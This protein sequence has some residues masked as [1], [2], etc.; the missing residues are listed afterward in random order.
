MARPAGGIEVAA[1][2]STEASEQVAEAF[3]A[4]GRA[5]RAWQ[6]YLPNNPTR[7]RAVELA[8]TSLQ[9]VLADHP[10]GLTVSVR[11]QAFAQ[12]GV[13]VY[14]ETARQT[15]SLPWLMYRDGVR[16]LTFL[17]GFPEEGLAKLLGVLQRARQAAPDE[18]DLVTLLWM[19]GID[20]FKYRVVELGEPG[21]F[22]VAVVDEDAFTADDRPFG[23][24]DAEGGPAGAHVPAAES[25]L[26]SGV[27]PGLVRVE[28]FDSA[29]VFLN[30]RELA[31]L[32]DEMQAEFTR[33]PRPSVLA[34]LLDIIETQPDDAVRLEAVGSLEGLLVDQLTTRSYDLSAAT[35]REVRETMRRATELSAQVRDALAELA[36]RLSEPDAIAQLLDSV[37]SS[38]TAT[39][40]ETLEALATEWRVG[41]LGP[42]LAWLASAPIGV[43]RAAVERAAE[44]LA[45]QHDSE[46]VRHLESPDPGTAS[47]AIR[48][49]GQLRIEAAVPVLGRLARDAAGSARLEATLAL[50]T[51]GGLA[52]LR[53]IEP[54]IEDEDRD[55]RLAAL[56]AIGLHRHA[57][58]RPRL[59]EAL[60]R[61]ELRSADRTEKTTLF[62]AF[63]A[64][65]GEQGVPLLDGLLNGRTLLGPRESTDIRA[66]AARALGLVGSATA[67]EALRR[68]VEPK[69]PV[70]RNEV[71]RALRGGR[72]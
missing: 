28:D 1:P 33:D 69:D 72:L 8:R 32:Q 4:I 19:S 47:T 36:M 31:A 58:A 44:R 20:A 56:R 46:L 24:G 38:E 16:S 27:P 42:L 14:E 54:L 51:I 48:L 12:D 6:L 7:E 43:A 5:F 66:C 64:I 15:D 52:A 61:K 55:L 70:V 25:S 18:D 23:G 29:L 40:A 26:P 3:R 21:E 30:A 68:C 37:H 9:R 2:E 49:C 11:Q 59:T 39:A 53:L 34:A 57:A 22:A 45:E 35:L 62:D 41:A 65:C 63:A 71:A 67:M 10:D 13:V 60:Q 17:P 50:S